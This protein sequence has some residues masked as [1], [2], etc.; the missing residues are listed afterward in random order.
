MTK[1]YKTQKKLHYDKEMFFRVLGKLVSSARFKVGRDEGVFNLW[2][3]IYYDV[4]V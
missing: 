4:Y 3:T 2:N 1:L